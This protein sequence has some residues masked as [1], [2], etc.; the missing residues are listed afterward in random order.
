MANI[1][2]MSLDVVDEVLSGNFEKLA[3]IIEPL[4]D[5]A[6]I[7]YV[8]SIEEQHS[9]D[10]KDFGLVLFHPQNGVTHKYALYTPELVELNLAYL[11]EK[12]NTLPDEVVKVAATNLATAAN[13]KNITIP[14]GLNEFKGSKGY[15]PNIL[16]TREINEINYNEKISS[17]AEP[18]T[19]ALEAEKKYPLETEDNVKQAIAYFARFNTEFDDVSQKLEYAVNTKIAAD[20]YSIDIDNT[21]ISKYAHL[22]REVFNPDFSDHVKIRESY[23]KPE[24]KPEV[25]DTYSDLLKRAEDI[26]PVKTAEVLYEI[27]KAAGI[28][29]IYGSNVVD[30]VMAT[31]SEPHEEKDSIDGLIIKKSSLEGLDNADLTELVGNDVIAEL[32]GEDGLAVLKSLP[33]P[34]RN[35]IIDKID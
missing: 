1:M 27:D 9:R 4:T 5:A 7:A 19:F 34:V 18:T 25:L 31:L 23:L 14:E 33:K 13:L 6:K 10:E 35:A 26:G 12:K 11:D 17:K 30:P 28:N 20:K 3:E 16:D 24:H 21:E 32:K 15:I 2:S 29:H 22:S 8:P